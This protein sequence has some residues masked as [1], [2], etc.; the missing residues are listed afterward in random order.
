MLT[1]RIVCGREA[2]YAEGV[3]RE[4]CSVVSGGN[5][6]RGAEEVLFSLGGLA[7]SIVA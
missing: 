5:Y 3:R 2:D 7:L 4:D 6:M 1:G